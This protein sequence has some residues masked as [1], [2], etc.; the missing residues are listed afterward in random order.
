MKSDLFEELEILQALFL[1]K[2]QDDDIVEK[3]ARWKKELEVMNEAFE[4]Y[5]CRK[6]RCL[7]L[8]EQHPAA[9]IWP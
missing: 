5:N 2:Q 3:E 6:Q 9:Q 1:Q 8:L 7:T 4:R